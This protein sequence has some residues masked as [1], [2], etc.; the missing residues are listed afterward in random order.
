MKAGCNSFTTNKSN[1]LG[2]WTEQDILK[3]IHD[4]ELPIAKVYG[5][6]YQKDLFGSDFSLTG[7]DR[8]GCMFCMFGVH[9]EKGKNR[10]QRM[11]T[12][13]PQI[14]DY[15]IRDSGLGLGK[16]LDFIGVPY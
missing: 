10:F 11:K 12:T 6:V 15:C 4:N 3:Y 1:P 5:D 2:F 8:T 16:V 14:Y 13:H 7:V 9:L